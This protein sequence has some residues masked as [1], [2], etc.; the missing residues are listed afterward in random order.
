MEEDV[1]LAQ[2]AG[3]KMVTI[4]APNVERW[5]TVEFTNGAKRTVVEGENGKPLVYEVNPF[6]A[7]G[8]QPVRILLD[9]ATTSAGGHPEKA[10]HSRRTPSKAF[11]D[12]SET[13]NLSSR[14]LMHGLVVFTDTLTKNSILARLAGVIEEPRFRNWTLNRQPTLSRLSL[15]S[16]CGVG[17]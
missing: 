4:A 16:N 3:V 14:A 13:R 5:F 9:P 8:F 7:K 17:Q 12:Q 1:M 15:S 2:A 11:G 10:A 6:E